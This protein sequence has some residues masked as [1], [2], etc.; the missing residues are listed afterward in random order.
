M[1]QSQSLN[2]KGLYFLIVFLMSLMGYSQHIFAVDEC[3]NTTECKSLW[4]DTATDCLDSRSA[5]SVC[6]CGSVSC[7]SIFNAPI[8][9]A[10]S[11][12][13]DTPVDGESIILGSA[14]PVN[15]ISADSDGSVASVLLLLDGEEVRYE[16]TAPYRWGIN[17]ADA[18][19]NNLS[20]GTHRL[21]AIATDNEGETTTE[22]ITIEVVSDNPPGGAPSVSFLTPSDG[23]SVLEGQGVYVEV[24]A[25]DIDGSIANVRLSVDG[26]FVRRENVFPYQWGSGGADPALQN[27]TVGTHQI[28][29]I[30]TDSDGLTTA[31]SIA[32]E[33][34]P[35]NQPPTG[36]SPVVSFAAP[37]DGDVLTVGDTLS[38]EV[39]A[40][41]PDGSVANVR[42]SVD[43]NFVRQENAAPYQW[44]SNAA[45]SILQSLSVGTHLLS[46]EAT[47]DSGEVTTETI[48]VTLVDPV[49]AGDCDVSGDL[50]Q[51]HRVEVLCSGYSANE[52]NDSTFTDLRFD[53]TFTQGA[54]SIRVP[55][56]FAANA[57]AADSGA[58]SGDHW[59]A[60]FSPP[61]TGNWNYSVSFRQG[62]DVAVSTDANAGSAQ[63]PL[64]GMSGSFSVAS[65]NA[66]GKDMRVRGLLQHVDG[67]R[68]LRFAGDNTVFIEAGMDS[69]ENIFGYSEFDNTIK[70]DNVGSCKGILHDFAAHT[71]DWQQGDPT[72]TSSQ[73]GKSLIGLVNYIASK[74]V[75]AIYINMNTV[76]G[77]GCDAHPWTVYNASGAVKTFDVSKL[78]QWE[79]VLGH[80][81]ENGILIHVMMQETENDQL[82]NNGDLGV[83]RKLYYRELISRFA[84]HPALQWNLGEENTNTTAQVK[85]YA[86]FIRAVDPYDHPIF[87]HTYPN[88]SNYDRYTG[89]LGHDTFDGPTFQVS[90][91]ST[92]ASE[93]G[94][95]VYGLSV[96]WQSQSEE[97]GNAWVVTFTEASGGQA[98]TPYENVT[99]QQRV[100]WMWAS[101]MSGGAGFEWYLKNDGSG[102]AYDLAVENLREFDDHW[103]QSG[104]L[105]EF[106]RGTLQ[107]QLG[108]DLQDLERDNNA[109]NTTSDWVL[110]DPGNAYVIFLREGGTTN[111][112]LPNNDSYNVLWM[113]PRTGV[114]TNGGS[115][116]GVGFQ[117]VGNPPSETNED[118]VLVVYN[119][120]Q[121]NSTADYIQSNGLVVMEAENTK[122]TLDLWF[123][124]TNI[125]G[126]TGS[127]YIEFNGNTPINGSAKSPL[128]YTFT[129]NQSGL[130][131]LHLYVAK[132]HLEVN[133]ELR[134]DIANDGYVR[135]EGDYGVGP[136]VGD[137]HQDDAPLSALQ[138]D[139][140]FYGGN[141]QQFAWSHGARLDLGGHTNKRVAVYDLKAGETY[142]FVLSGRS[143]YFKVDRIVFRHESVSINEAHDLSIGET[144]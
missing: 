14:V 43:G 98:P 25:T 61:S 137:L 125:N 30:A 9:V 62:N 108:I 135:L 101:V 88:E 85:S 47:D 22:M 107:N 68:Y 59:R 102:H 86:D 139:T 27:L 138:T 48:T 92:D 45:D 141:D 94:N 66:S 123:E 131:Y 38:V 95:G 42:L 112:N 31:A 118:W 3:N 1:S 39:L 35:E 87:M 136:N 49:T 72:W 53:V 93:S 117:S 69:P 126:F 4:G 23:T 76:S 127:S 55:G 109:T 96:D 119:T 46:A 33:V 12:S 63:G 54:T 89:L 21:T 73:R 32:I 7:A 91:I 106:F 110:S 80:M 97:N 133:G 116:Q 105:A 128:S 65:S 104:Y 143:Q 83:E 15:V 142:T 70:F 36:T 58:T 17:A 130:H 115:P 111:V 41:D 79:R 74:N 13:F 56:H 113:N 75:N 77:D 37:S 122:S 67:E 11:L 124:D 10:P 44:G 132:E 50:K 2:R 52:G 51:W 120:D 82:L 60:Y 121:N 81:T 90:N 140:K 6:M 64:N 5:N 24:V 71:N 103:D 26:E 8:N 20:V 28:T 40:T 16:Y 57:D 114:Y 134:T 144:R 129:V 84:H 34:V 78:D 18:S 100:Y 99:S 29:A 19:L